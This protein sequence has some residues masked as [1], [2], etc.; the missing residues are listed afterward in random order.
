MPRAKAPCPCGSG[1]VFKKC[2]RPVLDYLSHRP[3]PFELVDSDPD[4]AL[5]QGRAAFTRYTIWHATNTVPWFED[6]PEG[7]AD[8]T[9]IDTEALGGHLDRLRLLQQEHPDHPPFGPV[10][11][12]AIGLIDSDRWRASIIRERVMDALGNGGEA[13]A[14]HILAALDL[15]QINDTELLG[16]CLSFRED[17]SGGRRLRLVDRI[18]T[19]TRDWEER[20]RLL[21]YR[22]LLWE[23]HGDDAE[24]AAAYR[25]AVSAVPEDPA[26]EWAHVAIIGAHLHAGRTAEREDLV[27]RGL[28]LCE[29]FLQE[30]LP[31]TPLEVD[32]RKSRAEAYKRLARFEEEVED[33]RWVVAARGTNDDRIQLAQ[34]L[35]AAGAFEEARQEL[36]DINYDDL[37]DGERYDHTFAEFG[38][39]YGLEDPAVLNRVRLRLEGLDPEFP[40]WREIRSRFLLGLASRPE[41]M[42]SGWWSTFREALMLQPNFLGF[43]L[44]LGKL[45]GLQAKGA[46]TEE[47]THLRL[48]TSK[49]LK[50]DT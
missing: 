39:L 26:P 31:G 12:R 13:K 50:G 18:V 1:Q 37:T 41:P 16:L 19:E 22:G 20:V 29:R 27:Q 17:L 49:K 9:R 40:L 6:D 5:R 15:D 47:D 11:D 45:L 30:A 44:D 28:D 23:L 2:C 38:L 36:E 10:L 43:G 21:T 33:F 35:I 34:G 8:L 24:G 4:E 46:H 14:R 42:T 7:A 3:Q 25:D 48:A 32:L